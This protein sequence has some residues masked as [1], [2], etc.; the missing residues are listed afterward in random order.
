MNATALATTLFAMGLGNAWAGQ[1]EDLI[2]VVP[3]NTAKPASLPAH[4]AEWRQALGAANVVAVDSVK[5]EKPSGFGSMAVL[6]FGSKAELASW[7]QA[8]AA[9]LATPLQATVADVLTEGGA[10]PA[11][12][13]KPVYKISYY[14]L[15]SPRE[16]FQ[17]WV[18]GYLTK[19][20]DMQLKSGILTRYGM[21]LEHGADGRALLVLEY[22][23]A[24]TEQEAEPIKAGLSDEI[25]RV[26]QEYARQLELK[27]SLRTTQSWTLAVPSH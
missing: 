9:S 10:A 14:S 20:L 12:G 17:A 19:Y 11:A 3:E 1:G 18:D 4:V 16:D 27:E 13:S 6:N 26:D 2:V 24:R 8:N 23:D 22:T 15:T 5:R 7:R 21:Y 25:A